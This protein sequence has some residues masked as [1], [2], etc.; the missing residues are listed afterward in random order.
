MSKPWEIWPNLWKTE[1]AWLSYVRGGIRKGLW[2]N[3][4]P[5]L[6][7]LKL[8]AEMRD[9]LNPRSMKR[10]PK[11]KMWQCE[12]CEEWFT[13]KDIQVDHRRG[14]NSLRSVDEI[15]G[16]VEAMLLDCA[17]EDYAI[18]CTP[19]HKVKSNAEA[20]GISFEESLID[21]QVIE[22][23]KSKKDKEFLKQHGVTPASNAPSRREQL[24]GV[25]IKEKENDAKLD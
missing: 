14:H 24:R 22:I 3:Y 6:E 7:F 23:M 15:G 5:K 12:Q 13:S 19:C 10:F 2:K 25:L 17:T 20:K 18:M 16:F 8:K 11:V 21:K 9:N 1:S 4:P